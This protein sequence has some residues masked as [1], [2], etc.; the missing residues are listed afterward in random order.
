MCTHILLSEM[1]E[2]KQ[3]GNKPGSH[4]RREADNGSAENGLTN[5]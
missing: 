4:Y 1:L 2:L 3:V 5:L